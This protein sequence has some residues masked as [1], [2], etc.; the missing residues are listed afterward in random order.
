MVQDNPSRSSCG[1]TRLVGR[2]SDVDTLAVLV[3]RLKLVVVDT[4]IQDD[5][6]IENLRVDD[7]VLQPNT[8]TAAYRSEL[9]LLKC[10]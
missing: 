8:F 5:G 9:R 10:G 1:E 3:V 4:A 2:C 6:V 7:V